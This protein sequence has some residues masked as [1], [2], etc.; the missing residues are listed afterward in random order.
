MRSLPPEGGVGDVPDSP[1][2]AIIVVAAGSGTRLAQSS[3]K[4]FVEVAG[5]SILAHSL[6]AVFGL[7]E[8]AQ[9][10]VVAPAELVTRA[11]QIA[12]GVAGVASAYVTVVAGGSTRQESVAAGL[13]AL[14]TSVQIVLVHDAA[15]AFTPTEQF[16]RVIA[17]V[18]S[19]DAGVVPGLPVTDTIKR[20]DA[21]PD[22][23]TLVAETVDRS[24]LAAVQTPQGFPAADLVAAYAAATEDF[25][26]DAAVFAAANH[27]VTLVIG[28]ADAFKI[29]T[30]WDLRRAEVLAAPTVTSTSVGDLRSGLG[31]DVHAFDDASPLWLGGVY[32]PGERGLSG[33]SDG[34]VV[35]HA[36]CDALLS[37]AGLGD[38]G[39]RFG[40][41]DPRFANAHG[42]VFLTSTVAMLAD[43][44]YQT[45]NVSVQVV[46]NSPRIGPRR[47]EIE[48]R[49]STLVAAPVSISATTSDFLGFTGRGEGI[50]VI[51]TALV[52]RVP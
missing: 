27:P 30:P 35:A 33:H 22:G 51:A 29:T 21:A 47:A 3:P 42:D 19:S 37:A 11:R 41:A 20:T 10:I 26:D 43:A 9:V 44:G 49:L 1:S 28:D 36:V 16:E 8:P 31:I 24:Q 40:T 32:W 50:A 25:T 14:A 12:R 5:R 6:Q 34:D 7:S 39:S 17:A 2:V 45:Q 46:G 52:Q 23:Q 18:R 38:I 13:A 48:A 4:A 15:R